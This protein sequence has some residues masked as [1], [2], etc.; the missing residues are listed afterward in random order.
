MNRLL[1]SLGI[2]SEIQSFF[3]IENQLQFDYGAGIEVFDAGYHFVPSA[4]T[5]YLRGSPASRKV[6]VTCSVMEAI[7]WSFFNLHDY[8]DMEHHA[9][10]ALGNRPDLINFQ[11]LTALFPKRKFVLVFGCDLLGRATDIY[12]A[13][14]LNRHLVRLDIIDRETIGIRLEQRIFQFEQERLSLNAFQKSF[15][16]RTACRTS[17][18]KAYNSY[19]DQLIAGHF[20]HEL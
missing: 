12:V 9:F 7:A 15:R 8:P 18:P 4:E 3:D 6:V 17:K 1:N 20:P 14:T 2:P 11:G 10:A 19:L 5:Y 16:I 13:A